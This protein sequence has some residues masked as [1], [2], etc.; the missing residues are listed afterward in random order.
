M[1][2]ESLIGYGIHTKPTYIFGRSIEQTQKESGTG[3]ILALGSNENAYGPSPKAVEAIVEAAVQAH[4]YPDPVNLKLKQK[5]ADRYGFTIEEVAIANGSADIM[6]VISR[7]FVCPGDEVVVANPTFSEYRDKAVFNQGTPVV[8]DL[9]EDTYELDLD[10]MYE[11]VTDRTKL[12]W[13]C[14]PNNP[15]GVPVNGDE[16]EAFIRRLPEHVVAIVDEAYIE[17][18][19]DP[20]VRTMLPLVRDHNLI[21]LRTFSKIY[22]LG[23]MRVGYSIARREI[24]DCINSTVTSFAVATPAVEAAC[25]AFDDQEYLQ[26][27]RDGISEGRRYL[28]REFEALG[29]KVYPSQTNFLFV[30]A[31]MPSAELADRLAAQ[32]IVIRGNFRYPRITVGTKEDN[33]RLAEACRKI[34]EEEK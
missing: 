9:P 1:S 16:L 25:A 10:R 4:R 33:R 20:S 6:G 7:I 13:V 8:V 32:G 24:S 12:V 28:R 31:H 11:A 34:A 5:L 27:V 21:I 19:D 26:M 18:A 2:V 3:D 15:T 29:W 23:A 17:F 30:D 22:G 14:N